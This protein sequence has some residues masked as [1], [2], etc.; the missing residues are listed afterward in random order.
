MHV[1]HNFKQYLLW[2]SETEYKALDELCERT[3]LSKASV[4]RRLILSKPIKERL[5]ADFISLIDTIDKIGVNYNQLV[6]KVNTVGTASED[7]VKATKQMMNR[8][9]DL[10]WKWGE[11]WL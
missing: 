7:D 2:M 10:L 8:I 4:L 5:S 1:N 11:T 6:R 9:Y 3:G